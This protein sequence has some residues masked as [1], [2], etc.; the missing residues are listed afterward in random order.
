MA[1][2]C[3]SLTADT[4]VVW[5][6][7]AVSTEIAGELVALDVTRGVCFGLNQ[8]GTRIWQLI[9]VPRS[10]GKIVDIM[11]EEYDVSPEVCMKQTLSLLHDLLA[12]KLVVA[13]RDTALEATV[14]SDA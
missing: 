7:T 13:A 3:V 1:S 8:I 11:L 14:R 5:A 6:D 4:P 2:D 10:A 12:A 9:E